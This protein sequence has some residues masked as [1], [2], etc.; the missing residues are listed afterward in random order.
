[1][2]NI[3]AAFQHIHVYLQADTLSYTITEEYFQLRVEAF[4]CCLLHVLT[5]GNLP[6]L[7]RHSDVFEASWESSTSCVASVTHQRNEHLQTISLC[8]VSASLS[9]LEQLSS[10]WIAACSSL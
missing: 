4:M 6:V 9:S 2:H 10:R 7:K 3:H 1:M 5:P 8:V